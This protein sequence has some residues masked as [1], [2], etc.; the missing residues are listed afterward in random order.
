MAQPASKQLNN[1]RDGGK[2]KGLVPWPGS[3]QYCDSPVRIYFPD[4]PDNKALWW[5]TVTVLMT[6]FIEALISNSQE[7]PGLLSCAICSMYFVIEVVIHNVL[8]WGLLISRSQSKVI[9]FWSKKTPV[10]HCN[11]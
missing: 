2:G 11:L 5:T 8:L 9:K 6:Y 3:R 7:S 10:D 1:I 4:P